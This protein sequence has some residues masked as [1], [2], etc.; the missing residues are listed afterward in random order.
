M[1]DLQNCLFVLRSSIFRAPIYLFWQFLG[2][3]FLS[4]RPILISRLLSKVRQRPVSQ[5]TFT[6]ASVGVLDV[7]VYFF[8]SGYFASDMNG[9]NAILAYS[10]LQS[11]Q[12]RPCARRLVP[13]DWCEVMLYTA[14]ARRCYTVYQR[15]TIRCRHQSCNT[16]LQGLRRPILILAIQAG[17]FFSQPPLRYIPAV[18]SS[19]YMT[20]VFPST[21]INFRLK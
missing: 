8:C 9:R 20:S 5:G 2:S 6:H 14:F 21:R 19:G 12:L 17:M 15:M 13:H 7:C 1:W 10:G 3:S 16:A 4:S 18:I 11:S